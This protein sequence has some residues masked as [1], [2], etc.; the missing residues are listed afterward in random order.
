MEFLAET[1]ILKKLHHPNLVQ[2]FA[3]CTDSGGPLQMV[4]EYLEHGDLKTFMQIKTA[5]INAAPY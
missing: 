1:D 5:L 2:V 3:V 4:M